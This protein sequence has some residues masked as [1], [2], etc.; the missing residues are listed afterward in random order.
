MSSSPELGLMCLRMEP[1][2]SVIVSVLS[3][4][5]QSQVNGG[6]KERRKKEKQRRENACR[7]VPSGGGGG[8]P[9]NRQCGEK[10][11]FPA[12]EGL[13]IRQFDVGRTRRSAWRRAPGPRQNACC[14]EE[15]GAAVGLAPAGG[16]RIGSGRVGGPCGGGWGR[17]RLCQLVAGAVAERGRGERAMTPAV[18]GFGISLRETSLTRFLVFVCLRGVLGSATRLCEGT[19]VVSTPSS[20]IYMYSR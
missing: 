7:L 5:Q 16:C 20:L 13:L 1:T 15:G 3:L 9:I 12:L 10:L 17:L 4:K 2:R 11:G 14:G 8:P 6:R 19:R 18:E